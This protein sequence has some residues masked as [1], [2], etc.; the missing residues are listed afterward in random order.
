FKAAADPQRFPEYGKP[1][2]AKKLYLNGGMGNE[3]NPPPGPVLNV[4]EFD[5]DLGRSY[6]QIASEGRS[7]HRSQAQ[8]GAQ[9]A[10]PRQTRLQLVQK[11]VNVADDAPMFA[12]VL[13]KLPDRAQPEPSL[14]AN[15]SDLEQRITTIRQKVN[16]LR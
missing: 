12:G 3:Q 13:Y 4:G 5:P 11:P 6:S 8:G 15:L 10:G 16:L 1:W 7:L 9:D 14:S 2:Q